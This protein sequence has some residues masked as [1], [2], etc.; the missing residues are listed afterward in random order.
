MA[1]KQKAV[2]ATLPGSDGLAKL[3]QYYGSGPVEFTGAEHALYERHPMFDDVVNP[4]TAGPRDRFEAFARSVRD[5]LCQRWVRIAEC[6]SDVW[7][8]EPCPMP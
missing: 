5:I 8:V 3:R 7:N 2:S 6:A 4:A 1:T